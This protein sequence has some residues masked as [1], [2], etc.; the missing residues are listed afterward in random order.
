[1]NS[2]KNKNMGEQMISIETLTDKTKNGAQL[3]DLLT[4]V[5]KQENM[6]KSAPRPQTIGEKRS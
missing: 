3:G 2:K 5:L 6:D 1:M 4:A